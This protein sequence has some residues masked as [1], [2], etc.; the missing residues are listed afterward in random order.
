MKAYKEYRKDKRETRNEAERERK[1]EAMRRIGGKI[2]EIVGKWRRIQEEN[3]V[4][5]GYYD[6]KMKLM[7][8]KW[9]YNTFP[10]GPKRINNTALIKTTIS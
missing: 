10:D 7:F 2:D 1:R 8:I 5:T 9:K 4:K 6:M 3:Y